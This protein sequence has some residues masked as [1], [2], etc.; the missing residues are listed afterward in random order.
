MT[1]DYAIAD[2]GDFEIHVKRAGVGSR[3]YSNK[4]AELELKYRRKDEMIKNG[5]ISDEGAK[6]LDAAKRV[7]YAKLA[8]EHIVVRWKGSVKGEELKKFSKEGAVELLS[9]EGNEALFIDVLQV[10]TDENNFQVELDEQEV[11]N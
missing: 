5:F 1:N 2:Y 9:G 8:A 7:D 4:I 6:K 3:A 11:K 10:A